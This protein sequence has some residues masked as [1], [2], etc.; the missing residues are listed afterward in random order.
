MLSSRSREYV[1][2]NMNG[3]RLFEKRYPSERRA[4]ARA[5]GRNRIFFYLSLCVSVVCSAR[6][7]HLHKDCAPGMARRGARATVRYDAKR[8]FNFR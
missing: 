7:F 5:G 8:V 2:Q 3:V 6:S 1:R 4:R